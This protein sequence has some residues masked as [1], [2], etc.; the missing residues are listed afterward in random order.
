MTKNAIISARPGRPR[1]AVIAVPTAIAA[2]A[3]ETSIDR[4]AKASAAIAP[5]TAR[6]TRRRRGRSGSSRRSAGSRRGEERQREGHGERHRDVVVE[7]RG[8]RLDER[9]GEG[10]GE[11]DADRPRPVRRVGA[12]RQPRGEGPQQRRGRRAEDDEGGE[13]DPALARVP[14][15]ARPADRLAEERRHAVTD[16][17]DAPA[18][19]GHPQALAEEEDEREHGERV[20][21]DADRVAALDVGRA[22]HAAAADARQHL[23]VED[24]RREREERRL[25]PREPAQQ[26]REGDAAD[27]DDAARRL[28][29][30][31]AHARA[32]G[33]P[34]LTREPAGT[35]PSRRSQPIVSRR[36]SASGRGR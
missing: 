19:G 4:A 21:E 16:G 35:R 1:E 17:E 31:Q 14:R 10:E 27:V 11:R 26:E 12:E 15:Q 18:G 13:A 33:G 2:S 24:E 22:P 34:G 28:A 30:V 7:R 3:P 9:A 32:R 23:P 36:P 25:R 20:R 29:P 6:P 8:E 5:F